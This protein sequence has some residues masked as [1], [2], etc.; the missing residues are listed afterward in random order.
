MKT[1]RLSVVLSR[2]DGCITS[3]P[4]LNVVAGVPPFDCSRPDIVQ[5]F[6]R[7][8]AQVFVPDPVHGVFHGYALSNTLKILQC[9]P[10]NMLFETHHY[11]YTGTTEAVEQM[12][13]RPL[14]RDVEFVTTFAPTVFQEQ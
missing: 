9:D 1:N 10:A 11:W 8:F 13:S 6:C 14:A 4:T 3:L 7:D 5:L 12:P 2:S